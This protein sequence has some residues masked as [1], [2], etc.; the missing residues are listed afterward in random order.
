MNQAFDAVLD[1]DEAAVVGNIR[2]LAE[3]AC[4][5]RI[6]TREILPRIVA[7]LLHAERHALP[8]T[9]ELQDLDVDFVADI[10]DFGRMLDALPCHIGD[11]QQPVDT[12]EVDERAVVGQ[13]LDDTLDGIAFLQILQQ[14]LALGASTPARRP[15]GATRRRCCACWSSLMTL[16]SRLL[17]SR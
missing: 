8:F 6:T 15:H 3:Q 12:A 17:P 10:N 9:V 11:V 4:L 7:E 1:L 14:L 5:R 2:N 16:N 13:V